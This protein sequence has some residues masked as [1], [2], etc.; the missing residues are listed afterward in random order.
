MTSPAVERL[1][2]PKTAYDR[3]G[4]CE[5]PEPLDIDEVVRVR[6]SVDRLSREQRPEVVYEGGTRAVR[7]IHGCHRFDE[8]C[9]RLVR[10][11]QLLG[12]AE[13]LIGGPVYVYQFKVNLK[14]PREGAAWPWHQDFA[15]WHREDG[16]PRPDAVNLAVFLDE[17]H[18]ANGPLQVIPGSHRL[19]L[20]DSPGAP[21][22]GLPSGD[23]RRHVSADLEHTVSR[24]RAEGLAAEHGVRLMTGP[25][26]SCVAF[27]PSIV[28]SSS[29]NLSADRRAILLITYNSVG[30]APTHPIRPEFLVDRDTTPVT[31]LAG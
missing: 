26:G 20:I 13:A 6:A 11:P 24:E 7:A 18:E 31:R 2:A 21:G 27:H 25:A 22:Q 1:T 23:W 19:G 16:M 15:F 4:W 8:A 12:L 10:L 14:Q 5:S 30:N 29:D 28:H 3:D 9:A 17:V